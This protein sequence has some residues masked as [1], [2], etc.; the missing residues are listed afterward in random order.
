M[1]ADAMGAARASVGAVWPIVIAG[2]VSFGLIGKRRCADPQATA[3]R[4]RR[5]IASRGRP[6]S[7]ERRKVGMGGK[8]LPKRA[9]VSRM[10]R[11]KRDKRLELPDARS[12]RSFCH[13]E[14][15]AAK[16]LTPRAPTIKS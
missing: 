11:R 6:K 3:P 15:N 5:A 14:Y 1:G 9:N 13:L 7:P 2:F 16:S 4:K 10:S 12:A 8:P